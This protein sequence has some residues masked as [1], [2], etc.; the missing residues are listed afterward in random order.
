VPRAV[1]RRAFGVY[2]D[3]SS[4]PPWLG[5]FNLYRTSVMYTALVGPSTVIRPP[6]PN[7]L[8]MPGYPPRHVYAAIWRVL[9]FITYVTYRAWWPPAPWLRLGPV[10]ADIVHVLSANTLQPSSRSELNVE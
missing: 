7:T 6:Q 4:L 1:S 8:C 3:L 2:S 9:L 5:G 10:G